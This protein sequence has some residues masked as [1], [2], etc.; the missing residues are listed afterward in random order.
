MSNE[1]KHNANRNKIYQGG[2]LDASISAAA[3]AVEMVERDALDAIQKNRLAAA[4]KA[5]RLADL[6]ANTAI[7]TDNRRKTST[8]AE[9]MELAAEAVELVERE[10]QEA[11][12]KARFAAATLQATEVIA[13][14]G[15]RRM[16]AAVEA[17]ELAKIDAVRRSRDGA[18]TPVDARRLAEL[19]S[20]RSE[21]A[22]ADVARSEMDALRM[23]SGCGARMAA[24]EEA[25]ARRGGGGVGYSTAAVGKALR[26]EDEI[27]SLLK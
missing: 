8:A 24:M 6:E 9:V 12:Q 18:N 4:T 22:A 11:V 25:I 26:L 2:E 10:A 20:Y 5:V 14:D 19:E 27:N 7:E 21:L 3:K 1:L 23:D 16:G 15:C 17:M 13:T